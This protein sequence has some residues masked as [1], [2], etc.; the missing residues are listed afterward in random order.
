MIYLR[1]MSSG[2]LLADPGGP[3]PDVPVGYGRDGANPHRL[4]LTVVPGDCE[5]RQ[6]GTCLQRAVARW[7][8]N[9]DSKTPVNP[10]TCARCQGLVPNFA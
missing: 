8:C 4:H 3:V 7:W 10:G 1:E 5:H 2:D 6:T 9:R